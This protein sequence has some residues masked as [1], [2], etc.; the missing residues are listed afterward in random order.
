MEKGSIILGAIK[1]MIFTLINDTTPYHAGSAAASNVCKLLAKQL[2]FKENKYALPNIGNQ[3]RKLFELSK[4]QILS[5][6]NTS[7]LIIINGEGG[8]DNN[9]LLSQLELAIK[10]GKEIKCWHKLQL[11]PSIN[12]VALEISFHIKTLLCHCIGE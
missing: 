9:F 6:I 1:I 4:Q 3:N 2:G 8:I 11:L 5:A 10:S 7:D 12:Q